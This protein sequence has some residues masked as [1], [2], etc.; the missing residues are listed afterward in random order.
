MQNLNLKKIFLYLLI[1][2]V[3]VSALLGIFVILFGDFGEIEVKILMT[4][5]TITCTS[6]LG[7]ACGAY[8][9]TGRGKMLPIS[10]IIFAVISAILWIVLIWGALSSEQTIFKSVAS[11]TLLAVSCSH[12]SLLLLAKLDQRFI[13]SRYLVFSCVGIL[14]AILLYI[15]WLEPESD[16]DFIS[17]LIGVLSIIIAA[18]TVVTPVFH[19]LSRHESEEKQIDEEIS[20]LKKRLA[21]L[22]KRKTEIREQTDEKRNQE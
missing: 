3:S 21:E 17:R 5:V 20:E 12:L 6:I 8:F 2:S 18:V 14:S 15:I 11:S 22:E 10:G 9:E 16:S 13:W 1:A 19:K 4:T 7:L